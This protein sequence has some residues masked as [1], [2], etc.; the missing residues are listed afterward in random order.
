MGTLDITRLSTTVL[1][2]LTGLRIQEVI[3]V[4]G[5]ILV[6]VTP[7]RKTAHC[8]LCHRRSH[9]IHARFTRQLADLPWNGHLV[10]MCLHGRRFRCTNSACSR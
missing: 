7:T 1:P 10:R 3:V 4:E 5:T 6:A 2:H 9:R 8:P